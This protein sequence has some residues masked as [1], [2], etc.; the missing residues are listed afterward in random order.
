MIPV[1]RTLWGELESEEEEESEEE[2]E[3]EASGGEEDAGQYEE[4]AEEAEEETSRLDCNRNG[5][6]LT[7]ICVFRWSSGRIGYT[8]W[9]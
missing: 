1:D 4:E 3:E 8:Q 7:C 2:A 6:K 5:M 9:Y